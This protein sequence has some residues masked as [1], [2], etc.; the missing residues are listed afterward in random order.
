MNSKTMRNRALNTEPN[1]E[2]KEDT[3][4]YYTQT[5]RS[6]HTFLDYTFLSHRALIHSKKTKDPKK[7]RDYNYDLE[8]TLEINLE[9]LRTLSFNYTPEENLE[10]KN[11]IN[12]IKEKNARRVKN[13]HL[14][15]TKKNMIV[16]LQ[17]GY[18]DQSIK[19]EKNNEI[20]ENKIMDEQ[21]L[22][23]KKTE[24]ILELMKRFKVIERHLKYLALNGKFKRKPQRFAPH[25]F[26][27]NEY[28]Q[29]NTNY[30]KEYKQKCKQIEKIKEQISDIKKENILYKEETVLYRNKTTNMQLIR[31]VEFYR[32][33]IRALQT[34]IKILRNSFENM[35]QTLHY[36]NLSDSKYIICLSF[37]SYLIQCSC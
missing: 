22:F 29:L 36:L 24:Y 14:I 28:I 23:N 11:L 16:N 25:L 5:E 12:Q 33:I 26:K 17:Q 18:D 34:K 20:Y 6:H 15:K 30:K 37:F 9:M 10:I 4:S 1:K 8:K 31:V 19:K 21:F 27:I 7:I 2:D 35:T 3:M 13:K 32:R